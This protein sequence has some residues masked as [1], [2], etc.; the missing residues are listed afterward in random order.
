MMMMILTEKLTTSIQ[1]IRSAKRL[2]DQENTL[3]ELLEKLTERTAQGNVR[4]P[5]KSTLPSRVERIPQTIC[6]MII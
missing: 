1:A 6:K 4:G 3:Q 2:E 5:I